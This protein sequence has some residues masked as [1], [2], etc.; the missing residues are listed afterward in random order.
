MYVDLKDFLVK[1]RDIPSFKDSIGKWTLLVQES[2][3]KIAL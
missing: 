1:L 2:D 3:W